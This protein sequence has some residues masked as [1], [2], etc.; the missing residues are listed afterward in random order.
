MD[1]IYDIDELEEVARFYADT[2]SKLE[3]HAREISAVYGAMAGDVWIGAGQES[4]F[5]RYS[6]WEQ[7]FRTF[8]LRLKATGECLEN[9]TT[10][11]DP[12]RVEAEKLPRLIS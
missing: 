7:M 4:F 3:Q 6:Q 5:R 1:V 2:V 12:L 11:A 8:T 9:N 10:A